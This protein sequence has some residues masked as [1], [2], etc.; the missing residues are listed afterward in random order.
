MAPHADFP[1]TTVGS[2]MMLRRTDAPG[3]G[4]MAFASS[5]AHGPGQRGYC[6]LHEHGT[7][8]RT[9]IT[10]QRDPAYIDRLVAFASQTADAFLSQHRVDRTFVRL[11]CS[12][13]SADFAPRL[14]EALDLHPTAVIDT[15][16][17][18]GDSHSSGLISAHHHA[19]ISGALTSGAPCLWVGAGAGLTVGCALYEVS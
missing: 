10:V 1:M 14:A 4:P 17:T 3:F 9:A 11:I 6:D 8:S 16:E 5:P 7:G 18:L 2:A 19:R 12:Q 15:F 13:P